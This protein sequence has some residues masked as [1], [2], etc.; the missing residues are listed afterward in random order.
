MLSYQ[1][2]IIITVPDPKAAEGTGS[3]PARSLGFG[4]GQA[5]PTHL[6]WRHSGLLWLREIKLSVTRNITRWFRFDV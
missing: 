3:F 2:K 6:H 4:L 1:V 5:S